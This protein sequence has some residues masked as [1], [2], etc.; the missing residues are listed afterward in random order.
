MT[1]PHVESGSTLGS[2]DQLFVTPR[3]LARNHSTSVSFTNLS[4]FMLCR[5]EVSLLA[6]CNRF[7]PDSARL[8]RSI[9]G[10]GQV[11]SPLLVSVRGTRTNSG[12]TPRSGSAAKPPPTDA[13]AVEEHF[14]S[15]SGDGRVQ[16]SPGSATPRRRIR[17]KRA[18]MNSMTE[19][20]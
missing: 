19:Q 16:G 4:P 9:K 8:I 1:P 17:A 14:E 20:Q 7:R 5:L 6:A 3:P 11:R 18:A 2:F 15:I 12:Q 13:L 10:T